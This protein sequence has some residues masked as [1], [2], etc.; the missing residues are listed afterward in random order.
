MRSIPEVEERREGRDG[1]A[2]TRV[3]FEERYLRA[4]EWRHWWGGRW[5]SIIWR[6][7]AL[8]RYSISIKAYSTSVDLSRN[9]IYSTS[10]LRK[11]YSTS[12]KTWVEVQC[13]GGDHKLGGIPK[14]KEAYS[15]YSRDMLGESYLGVKNDSQITS[16]TT[17]YYL[18]DYILHTTY[19][20]LLSV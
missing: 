18:S 17:S 3:I 1:S 14:L 9:S 7:C 16:N 12:V 2:D 19:Y 20:I 4:K 6:W 5:G 11:T 8:V 13:A 10:D 15:T